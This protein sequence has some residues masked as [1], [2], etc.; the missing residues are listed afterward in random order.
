MP[1]NRKKEG[2]ALA[3]LSIR[4]QYLA[5]L[6]AFVSICL[7]A[8]FFLKTKEIAYD[9]AFT[10]QMPPANTAPTTFPEA[11]PIGVDPSRELVIENPDV[12]SFIDEHYSFDTTSRK[13]SLLQKSL[14]F[15][16][17]FSWYQNLASPISRILVVDSGERKE[18]V[19]ANF[20]R[21]L[22]WDERG[23]TVFADLVTGSAPQLAD[24][25]FF[26]GHYVLNKADNSC[27]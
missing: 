21:I 6:L 11:F 1:K 13:P 15:L 5:L 7:I 26:P 9:F 24:G 8:L 19:A 3:A 23:K 16:T 17:Q 10:E 18:E 12:D 14:A 2:R 27:N 25:K 20:A 22:R 4:L